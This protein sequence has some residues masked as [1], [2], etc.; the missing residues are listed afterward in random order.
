MGMSEALRREHARKSGTEAV[1][2]KARPRLEGLFLF[3]AELAG[4]VPG[5]APARLYVARYTNRRFVGCSAGE[6]VKR[7]FSLALAGITAPAWAN[8]GATGG[9]RAGSHQPEKV[10]R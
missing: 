7:R 8:S 6:E 10:A 2:P 9:Y 3:W 5:H 4:A 1:W